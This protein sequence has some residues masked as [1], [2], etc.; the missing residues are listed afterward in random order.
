M[1]TGGSSGQRAKSPPRS[2]RERQDA[3]RQPKESSTI[4]A[5]WWESRPIG[6]T[7]RVRTS[8]CFR[9]CP[10]YSGENMKPGGLKRQRN[11]G[12]GE[13]AQ[14]GGNAPIAPFLRANSLKLWWTVY[15]KLKF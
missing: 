2:E 8:A 5:T 3:R 4:S 15:L 1:L 9:G 11:A 7:L 12:G 14:D 13:I 6:Q 10:L